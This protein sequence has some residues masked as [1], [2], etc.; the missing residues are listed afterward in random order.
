MENIKLKPAYDN[1]INK[2][3]TINESVDDL[4]LRILDDIDIIPGKNI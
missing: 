3:I 1:L 4:S 2:T